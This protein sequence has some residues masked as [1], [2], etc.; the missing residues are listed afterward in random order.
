MQTYQLKYNLL[1]TYY[2]ETFARFILSVPDIHSKHHT[3]NNKDT[4]T[5]I[6]SKQVFLMFPRRKSCFI[7]KA[8][9]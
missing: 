9:T 3:C 7:N 8:L 1:L 6:K 5:V 4:N 2:M